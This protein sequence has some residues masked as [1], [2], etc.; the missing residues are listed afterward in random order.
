MNRMIRLFSVTSVIKV[1]PRRE[2]LRNIN[3]GI[4]EKNPLYA[5]SVT[6]GFM[7]KEL[8]LNTQR[9]FIVEKNLMLAPFVTSL[10]VDRRS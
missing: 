6:S 8:S 4:E 1:L 10:S 3:V 2:N 5:P 9:R 7:R